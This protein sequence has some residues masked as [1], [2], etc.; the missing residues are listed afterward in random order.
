MHAVR[1]LY[2]RTDLL[3][4]P[5]LFARELA[6]LP[7]EE[8]RDRIERIRSDAN[9]RLHLAAG[10]LAAKALRDAGAT[11][12]KLSAGEYGKPYLTFSGNLHFNLSHSGDYALCAVSDTPVGADVEKPRRLRP[13]VVRRCMRPEEIRWLEESSDPDRA[14]TRLWTRKESYVK[15]TGAGLACPFD[16]FSVLTQGGLPDSKEHVETPKRSTQEEAAGIGAM[17]CHFTEREIDGHFFC[18]CTEKTGEVIFEE[19][20]PVSV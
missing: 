19:F 13:D 1:C 9:K 10:I 15:M 12:L 4:D 18:V 11:D 14:F 3:T 20:L 5:E 17:A 6:A 16:S 7:W 2:M 8:R